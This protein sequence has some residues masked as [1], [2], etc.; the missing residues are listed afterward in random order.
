MK[1]INA[2][3]SFAALLIVCVFACMA[4]AQTS[5]RYGGSY[6]KGVQLF[7]AEDYAGAITEFEK[8][9]ADNP[10]NYTAYL[11]HGLAYTALGQ[12]DSKAAN[13]W[14]KM[15]YDEKW[16]NTYRLFMGLGYWQKG[17][18]NNAK[19]WLNEV[20]KHPETP[21]AKLAQTF[22]KSVLADGEAVPIQFWATVA[23][24]PGSKTKED[25]LAKDDESKETNNSKV[26]EPEQTQT[27]GA[28]PSGGLWKATIS[29]GYKGQTLSFRV[30]PDGSTISA[31]TFQG[32]LICRNSRTENT[33]LAPLKNVA[34]S[35]GVFADKQ[36]YEGQI[37]IDFNGTFTSA[38]TA[39]GTYRVMSSNDC[40]TYELK[41]T[42]SRVGN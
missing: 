12:L 42:A 1:K 14:L 23:N 13:I 8:A 16:K 5:N 33:Q 20:I 11:W 41:W 24:L 26:T 36:L 22:L 40:D 34:V 37:R 6:A 15:P 32:Y 4:S 10:G 27:S 30:S 28:K 7:Y 18:T 2:T 25:F 9:E 19:Y 31:I 29:N 38:A 35:G 39:S 3:K 17:E 21:A